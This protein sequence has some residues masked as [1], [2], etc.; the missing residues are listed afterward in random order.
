LQKQLLNEGGYIAGF[1]STRVQ[2]ESIV[3]HTLFSSHKALERRNWRKTETAY[4]IQMQEGGIT[5]LKGDLN[6]LTGKAYLEGK[7]G[8]YGG[9]AR[10]HSTGDIVFKAA[11]HTVINDMW[12]ISIGPCSLS[13]Q[14]SVFNLSRVNLPMFFAGGGNGELIARHDLD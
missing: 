2:A 6:L 12:K 14:S 7:I 5:S 8:S 1:E 4:A 9:A 11:S 13:S 10:V 3:Q